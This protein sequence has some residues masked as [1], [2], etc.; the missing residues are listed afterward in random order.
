MAS[1]LVTP[2]LEALK[3]QHCLLPFPPFYFLKFKR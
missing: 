3:H 2:A 1:K